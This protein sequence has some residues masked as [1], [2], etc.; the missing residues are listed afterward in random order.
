MA[1][2]ELKLNKKFVWFSVLAG[3]LSYI[4]YYFRFPNL[5]GILI[6]IIFLAAFIKN[7]GKKECLNFIIYL[8]IFDLITAPLAFLVQSN[9]LVQ[10]IS[11]AVNWILFAL[12][13]RGLKSLKIWAFYLV[14]IIFILSLI[15]I[16][17]SIIAVFA[18]SAAWNLQLIVASTRILIS[19][20][21]VIFLLKCLVASKKYFK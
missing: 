3:L 8:I 11:L 21:L 10:I 2:N 12:M 20:V 6:G 14:I 16:I 13:I 9:L 15:N 19:L 7:S 18:Q 17:S 5:Y 1:K 4:A